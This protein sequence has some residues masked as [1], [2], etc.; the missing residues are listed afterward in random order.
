MLLVDGDEDVRHAVDKAEGQETDE[1]LEGDT[2]GRYW[3]PSQD[4]PAGVKRAGVTGR[5][6]MSSRSDST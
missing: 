3:P 6:M 2:A 1:K 4:Q 5:A